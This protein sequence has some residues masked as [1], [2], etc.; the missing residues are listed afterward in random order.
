MVGVGVGGSASWT[1]WATVGGQ[2]QW[3]VL[4][5]SHSS[6]GSRIA[7]PLTVLYNITRNLPYSKHHQNFTLM[8][9]FLAYRRLFTSNHIFEAWNICV[10]IYIYLVISKTWRF[11]ASNCSEIFASIYITNKDSR[12]KL[13]CAAVLRTPL[14]SMGNVQVSV[15]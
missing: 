1:L 10:H 4:P 5:S 6:P 14:S 15:S 2:L 8:S 11:N 9:Y 13:Y 7:Q 12:G 3:S